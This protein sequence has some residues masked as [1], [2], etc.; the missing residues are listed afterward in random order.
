[1]V[2]GRARSLPKSPIGRIF[3]NTAWLLGG[4]G[5]GALCGIA[6]LTILTSSSARAHG[7]VRARV[8]V[9]VR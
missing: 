3:A 5:F 4:K 1:M 9:A 2:R 7:N 8:R 6:Y